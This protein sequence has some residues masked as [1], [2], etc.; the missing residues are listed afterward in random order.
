MLV[1]SR[2]AG[3]RIQIGDSIV[4]TVV[5][6]GPQEVRLGIDAPD[7]VEIVRS[8]LIQ[9]EA[10]GGTRDIGDARLARQAMGD[11]LLSSCWAR[12]NALRSAR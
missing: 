3:E 9:P 6:V 10:A 2:R 7:E 11:S 5:C 8:E 4:V 1:L 12:P